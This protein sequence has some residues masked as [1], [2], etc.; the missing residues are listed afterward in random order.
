[1][2]DLSI[3][4]KVDKIGDELI[5]YYIQKYNDVI[6]FCSSSFCQNC[7]SIVELINSNNDDSL[8]FY[9]CMI[10]DVDTDEYYDYCNSICGTVK[11]PALVFYKDGKLTKFTT[12]E[13]QC[14]QHLY[15]FDND[16]DF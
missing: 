6:I 3:H 2:I 12:G 7:K 13:N 4:D 8:Y 11:I 16:C 15:T 1:M 14:K 5:Q 9:K 10:D